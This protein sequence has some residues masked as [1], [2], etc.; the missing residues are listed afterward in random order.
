MKH[1]Y[2][3]ILMPPLPGLTRL[4][5]CWHPHGWLAVGHKT[6]PLRGFRS[7]RSKLMGILPA[8]SRER[9]AHATEITHAARVVGGGS[10]TACRAGCDDRQ[11][12][13]GPLLSEVRGFSRPRMSNKNTTGWS[14][15]LRQVCGMEQ[16]SLF[17]ASIVVFRGRVNRASYYNQ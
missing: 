14:G 7:C 15:L 6:S 3:S 4:V 9:D 2:T 12:N 13:R 10:R 5:C 1:S 8:P 16:T 11:T 17:A